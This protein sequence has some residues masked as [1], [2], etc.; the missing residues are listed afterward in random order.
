MAKYDRDKETGVFTPGSGG[1]TPGSRNRLTGDFLQA[2]ADDFAEFGAGVI[3]IVRAERPDRYLSIVASIL[4]KELALT[5]RGLED[6]TDDELREA[7]QTIRQL[8]ADQ[9]RERVV[10][11]FDA[12]ENPSGSRH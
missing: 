8:R 3:R 11:A 4:P 1:R 9:D 6:F 10:S 2:L 12:E 5:E 7:I